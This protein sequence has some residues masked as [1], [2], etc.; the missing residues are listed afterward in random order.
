MTSSQGNSI[1]PVEHE[2]LVGIRRKLARAQHQLN[3]IEREVDTDWQRKPIMVRTMRRT[4]RRPDLRAGLASGAVS[5][6]RVEALSRIPVDVGLCEHIDISGAGRRCYEPG[7]TPKP[8]IGPPPTSIS[9]SNH[10]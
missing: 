1:T 4:G 9:S 10:P 2:A 7:S 8:N 6:D 5:F 3:H